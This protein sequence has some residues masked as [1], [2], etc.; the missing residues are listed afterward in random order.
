MPSPVLAVKMPWLNF[1]FGLE[2]MART[3]A[4]TVGM[5]SGAERQLIVN[6]SR[7]PT[8]RNRPHLGRR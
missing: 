4:L 1:H 2:A 8:V 3:K 5:G 6:P 7:H